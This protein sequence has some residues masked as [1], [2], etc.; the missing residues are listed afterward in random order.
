[1]NAMAKLAN[2][3]GMA[4]CEADLNLRHLE[5]ELA[6]IDVML[7]R[8]L[9]AWRAAGRDPADAFRGLYVTACEA[10]AL[11]ARP[12][13]AGCAWLASLHPEEECAWDEAAA[14]AEQQVAALVAG[15]RQAGVSLRLRAL[16]GVFG[17]SAFD[18]D[19]VLLALA[20]EL[21]LRYER[22]YAY[23]QD[24]VTRKRPTVDLTLSLLCASLDERVARQACFAADAPLLWNRVVK[25]LADPC[26]VE[27]P[28]L[29]HYLKLDDQIVAYLLGHTGLDRRLASFCQT[30]Q[31]SVAWDELPLPREV[32]APLQT[33]AASEREERHPLILCLHGPC[34]AERLALAEAL[35]GEIGIEMLVVD[36]SRAWEAPMAFDEALALTFREAWL[37]D[38]L[39][40][41]EGAEA[42]QD[43]EHGERREH[44]EDMLATAT[45]VTVLSTSAAWAPT[46]RHALGIVNVSLT[47]PD[48]IHRH[49]LWHDTLARAGISLDESD[50]GTLAG[51]FRLTPVQI[52]DAVACAGAQG[53]GRAAAG[54]DRGR[55]PSLRDLLDAARA[56]TGHDLGRLARKIE[57]VYTWDDMVLPAD[58][59]AQL[60]EICQRVAHQHRVLDEWG[61]GRKLSLGKGVTALFAGPSGT[62]KTMAAEVIA[63]ELGLDLY[64]IDLAGVVSKYIGE[65]E[66]NLDRIFTAAENANAILF[67]DEA[68][69]LF[70]KRSEVRDSHD[71]YANIEISYLLQK[72]EAYGGIAI[73]ATNLRQNLDDAFVRRLAFTVHFPLPEEEN[74]RR[75]WQSIWPAALPLGE[76]VDLDFLAR[77]FKLSG[78]NIRNIALAASFLAAED[79]QVVS[80]AHLAQATRREYQ[81][82]GKTLSDDEL[83]GEKVI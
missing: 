63:N 17:L 66:K 27:P 48:F 3:V 19:V 54:G 22:L 49:V 1:M 15:A 53:R 56:Q 79:G 78:G 81:K 44:V 52:A 45:G 60:R 12:L 23:L 55:P 33:M 6:R 21:D 10:G 80:M 50:A 7:R 74:R 16:A 67:F 83:A 31:P 24:D 2:R 42:A 70:G 36:L 5:A 64:Q 18:I 32:I 68:D 73:L 58:T 51:R 75:I 4:P 38:A 39:L 61:F 71:R 69:A 47:V 34:R 46:G 57:P 20:P 26:H 29:A 14:C 41:L 59:A 13:G 9:A 82:M 30:V 35:A 28:L 72:M 40:Y 43:D 77:Q 65:T 37:Q 25:L 76:D 62:G 8:R 11:A